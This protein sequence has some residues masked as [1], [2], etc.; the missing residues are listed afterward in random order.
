MEVT[1]RRSLML[2]ALIL[3]AAAV[4]A[5][6]EVRVDIGINLPGPPAFAIIP[7]APVYYAPQAPANIFFY[8]HQYWA[9]HGNGWYVGPT[10]NGPWA[11]V[12]PFYVPAPILRVPV[13]YYHAPPAHWRGWT[14][15][16]PPRWDTHWGRDWREA[17]HEREW[18]EREER[19]ERKH[20]DRQGDGSRGH[21]RGR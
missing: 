6:A 17:A 14:H 7:G 8:S 13:R 9:F 16:A 3:V 15:G 4:P 5:R 1:M 10:W 2:A 21:G 12:E 19:W 20:D 11:V 18:R